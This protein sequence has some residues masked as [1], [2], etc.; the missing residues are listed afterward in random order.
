[1]SSKA[2]GLIPVNTGNGKLDWIEKLTMNVIDIFPWNDNFNTGL[3]DV[4]A[5][6]RKL[7]EL[8]NRLASQVAYGGTPQALDAIFD[9]LANY[10]VYHFACEEAIW[11]T[12]FDADSAKH[13]HL[14][15]HAS[16]GREVG[17]LK[18][19]LQHDASSTQVAESALAFLARWLA[20]HILETDRHMAYIVHAIRQGSS[21]EIA[22]AHALE[23]MAGTTRVLID[24]ILSI[25]S[26]LSSNTLNLMRELDER[27]RM[28]VVLK[29]KTDALAEFNRDFETFLSQTT[30]FVYFKDVNGRFRFCSQSLA[31]ITGHASWHE[32]VGKQNQDVFAPDMVHVYAAA[33]AL[34]CSQG[35]PQ[36]NQTDPF[37][38]A[39]GTLGYVQTNRWPLYDAAGQIAGIF[40]ISRDIT[41]HKRVHEELQDHKERLELA[42]LHNG[43]GIWDW[44]L[45]TMNMV[46][47][48][49]M[50][51]L[52][53]IDRKDFSGAVDAWEKSLHPEDRAR[54]AQ[55]IQDALADKKP[56]DT[57][58]R[59]IWPNG[60]IH[61][62][63][64]VAKVF[65]DEA[66]KPLRMLG[67][68]I[69]I[70]AQKLL[71][72][73]LMRQARV[74]FLTELSSRGYF[75]DQAEREL[76]RTVRYEKPL[77][78]LMLDI[79]NFKQIN[80]RYGHRMGDAALKKLASVCRQT[81]RDVDVMGR[82]GGEEFAILLPET[83]GGKAMEV[84]ERLRLALAS[85]KVPV[86]T[87]GLPIQFTVSIGVAAL[88]SPQDNMDVLFSLADNA[89]Y[90]AKNAG[91]N[92]VCF[93]AA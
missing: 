15:I 41:E 47:D 64:A 75:M 11:D 69:D 57:E 86:P 77:S 88:S 34:V 82:V 39:S 55:E 93:A 22:K 33:E 85:A 8:L 83:E 19:A 73:E 81:L 71:S 76:A 31:N 10:A 2:C 30:D 72:E 78:L 37:Y 70:T 24:I 29:E 5:Q 12:Y 66:A 46:W 17:R 65:R 27:R 74:D 36:I 67:T 62:I 40:G 89:L 26:T 53:N 18:A 84:A 91:R 58:F 59:V 38:D 21:M 87:G 13:D 49:S 61:H 54:A 16:F 42:T 92:Q 3:D 45:Q 9:E 52:Y 68:N 14:A 1:M 48:D 32:M 25:Y 20:S 80:D 4:D 51:A 6:H 28:A 35:Q 50:F 63:K 44:N 7:A 90:D 79:D 60:E 43:V 23:Q 56:F